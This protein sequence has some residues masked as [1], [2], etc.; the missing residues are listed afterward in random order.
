MLGFF[1]P[2]NLSYFSTE[3]N[4]EWTLI[5]VTEFLWLSMLGGS[6]RLSDLEKLTKTQEN[7][8]NMPCH[9]FKCYLIGIIHPLSGV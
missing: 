3:E 1:S 4:T 2:P 5:A 7:T 6:N 9:V 8:Q